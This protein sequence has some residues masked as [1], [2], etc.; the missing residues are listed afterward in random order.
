MLPPN[1]ALEWKFWILIN[2][3]PAIFAAVMFLLTRAFDWKFGWNVE[4]RASGVALGVGF[5]MRAAMYVQQFTA[6]SYEEMRWLHWGNVIFAGV[7][8]GTTC[9]WGDRFHWK[10]FTAIAWLFLYIEEPVWM[11]TLL[12]RSAAA[13]QPLV[14]GA[15]VNPILQIALVVEAGAMLIFGV[16]LFL[17]NRF[18]N[19]LSWKPDLVSARILSGWPLAYALWAP[20]LALAPTFAEARGGV[21]VNMIWLAAWVAALLIWRKQFDL[22]HRS[23]RVMLGTSAALLALLSVG[24]LAQG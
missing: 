3:L 19:L 1:L 13:L 14:T 10:R 9:V 24:F 5:L 21:I 22:S 23:T 11:L 17:Y 16:A 18:P 4:H 15:G 7:L 6:G 8:L 12:P 20:T 2:G